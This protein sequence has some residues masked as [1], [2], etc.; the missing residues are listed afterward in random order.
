MIFSL[1]Q[2]SGRHVIRA[3][4]KAGFIVRRQKGSHAIL[5]HSKDLSRR[6]IV[7][8]HGSKDI[9]PGTLRAIL[10]GANLTIEEFKELLK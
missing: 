6:A 3:L 7:P 4:E 5:V 2:V 1:P 8:V 10:K 9:K